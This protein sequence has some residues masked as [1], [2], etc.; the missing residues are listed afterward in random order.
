MTDT[1]PTLTERQCIELSINRFCNESTDS[2]Q[3][4]LQY[5][6]GLCAVSNKTELFSTDNYTLE[7]NYMTCIPINEAGVICFSAQVYHNSVVVGRTEPQQLTLLSCNLNS[8]HDLGVIISHVGQG[9]VVPHNTVVDLWC[10]DFSLLEQ[11]RCV[12]GTFPQLDSNS[13]H[14][15]SCSEGKC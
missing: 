5:T 12:N 4:Q 11:T 3:A 7:E 15:N 10:Y 9:A 8:L 13:T 6:E 2:F 14:I 1:I